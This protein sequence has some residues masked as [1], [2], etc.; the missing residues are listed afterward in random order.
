M[1]L[2]L[3]TLANGDT[4]YVAKHNS[5]YGDIQTAV[6]GILATLGTSSAGS[7]G[8][9]MAAL[10]GNATAF[11]GD[12]S[13]TTSTAGTV[14]TVSSGYAW[15]PDL[16]SVLYKGSSTPIDFSGQPAATYYITLGADGTPAR[17]TVS[18]FALYSVVWTGSAFG[19]ITAVAPIVPGGDISGTF[20][21]LSI[22]AGAVTLAKLANLA[23]NSVIG[24]NTGSPAT[25]VAVPIG[26][27][28]GVASLDGSGKVPTSQLPASVLGAVDYQGT[29]NASTNS[30][31]ITTGS[32]S[33]ANKG[34]Y[35]KVATAGTT[36][37]D[38]VN[39]W[40][41][42]DWII[43]DGVSWGKIDNTE[44]V[45]SVA[46]LSGAITAAALTAAL[47][48]FSSTLQGLVP[49]SGGGTSTFLRADGSWATPGSGGSGGG[50]VT[51]VGLSMPAEFS[52]S[53]SPVTGSG[54]LTAAKA[55]QSANQVYAGPTSG[56]A[57]APAFRALVAAD[58]PA[59]RYDIATFYPGVPGNSQLVL[60][61]QAP[62]AVT[63][64]S[65]GTNSQAS[66]GTAATASTTF[67]I[68]QNGSS[69]GTIVWSASGTAG[70]FTISSTINIAAGDVLTITGPATADATLA[71]VAITLAG[72]A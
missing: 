16:A 8:N 53:G 6:N 36:T 48:L 72:T 19:A 61:W 26:G 62:R 17:Q 44:A 4:N 25:P 70:A 71:D 64:P 68:K 31:S 45:S 40:G 3:Q 10:F 1:T 7:T 14:L 21:A 59:M 50:S 13:Y 56:G 27:A 23:A 18:T 30:P 33:S 9:L 20:Q 34:Y 46:G 24:N 39:D 63:I 49:A 29:W 32:A 15:R 55:N 35:Y 37:V 51:S 22:V 42:G 57:A 54:T 69:V 60:R 28:N 47:N 11:I 41:V 66:A 2:A 58:V 12:T 43:S 65:G 38:G 5:N 67:T 52:V